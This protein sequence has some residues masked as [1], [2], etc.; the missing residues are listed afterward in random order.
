MK[1]QSKAFFKLRDQV[2]DELEA[3][4]TEP[5]QARMLMDLEEGYLVASITHYIND[6]FKQAGVQYPT[7]KSAIFNRADPTFNLFKQRLRARPAVL[8]T[9]AEPGHKLNWI[10]NKVKKDNIKVITSLVVNEYHHKQYLCDWEYDVPETQAFEEAWGH[11][12][13]QYIEYWNSGDFD[14]ADRIFD[15]IQNMIGEIHKFENSLYQE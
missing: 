2:L 13:G 11:M 3:L 12:R 7:T 1:I 10:M 6:R 8:A 15:F 9:V 4:Y 5:D 14:R